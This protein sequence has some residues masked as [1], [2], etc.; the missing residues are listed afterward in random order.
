[1]CGD[2]DKKNG[3]EEK[4]KNLISFDLEEDD[5]DFIGRT[6]GMVGAKGVK[7]WQRNCFM[8]PKAHGSATS[9]DTFN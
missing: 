4:P 3:W 7:T 5:N 1:V 2:D 9:A 8:S 6:K